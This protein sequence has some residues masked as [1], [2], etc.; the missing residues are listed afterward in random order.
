M[1]KKNNKS[2]KVAN[3]P[4]KKQNVTIN[5]AATENQNINQNHNIEKESMGSNTRR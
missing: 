2:N 1:T 3:N 5:T 4:D